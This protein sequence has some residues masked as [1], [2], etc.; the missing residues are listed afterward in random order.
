MHSDGILARVHGLRFGDS[1]FLTG[2]SAGVQPV[3]CDHAQHDAVTSISR[4]AI[5]VPL[6]LYLAV[7]I[8]VAMLIFS[9][10]REVMIQP[11]QDLL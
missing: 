5:I 11:I 1:L 4:L 9:M 2:G 3:S 10:F 6:V 8:G 7:V